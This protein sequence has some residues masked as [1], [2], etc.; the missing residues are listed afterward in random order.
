MLDPG[1][2]HGHRTNLP[3]LIPKRMWKCV[4]SRG[5]SRPPTRNWWGNLDS[6]LT[7]RH[8][9]ARDLTWMALM[10]TGGR[11]LLP[12]VPASGISECD[13]S[14]ALYFPIQLHA[15]TLVCDNLQSR[16]LL[17]CLLS[18]NSGVLRH[19]SRIEGCGGLFTA[20]HVTS[21]IPVW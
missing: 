3:S 17:V 19:S 7:E 13:L 16:P 20:S 6:P 9:L 21:L 2:W 1:F 5:S 12:N 15:N 8:M 18:H 10:A 11:D 14:V 4:I